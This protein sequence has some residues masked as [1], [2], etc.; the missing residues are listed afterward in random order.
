MER[1]KSVKVGEPPWEGVSLSIREEM[2]L[3]EVGR[4]HGVWDEQADTD[5]A[6]VKPSQETS[7]ILRQNYAAGFMPA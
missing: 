3:R 5:A 6:Q 7:V 2:G 4:A 1:V